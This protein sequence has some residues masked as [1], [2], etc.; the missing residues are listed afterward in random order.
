MRFSWSVSWIKIF[1][2]ISKTLFVYSWIEDYFQ[3]RLLPWNI[4]AKCISPYRTLWVRFRTIRN[5]FLL[6]Y[7]PFLHMS[8]KIPPARLLTNFGIWN[9]SFSKIYTGTCIRLSSIHQT[10]NHF[11]PTIDINLSINKLHKISLLKYSLWP[12]WLMSI[13]F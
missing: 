4:R 11:T 7:P 10:C 9:F 12:L 13:G 5:Q 8:P 1:L 6:K 2:K 3:L